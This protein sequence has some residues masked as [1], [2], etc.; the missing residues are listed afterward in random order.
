[1]KKEK[2]S[3]IINQIGDRHIE[4]AADFALK[5]DQRTREDLVSDKTHRKK[6]RRFRR[7]IA[8]ACLALLA[9]F[10]S[11]AFAAALEI[12]EYH[13]AAAFFDTNGLSADGL[14]RRDVKAVYRDITTNRFG[15]DK[16]AEVLR[17]AVPDWEKQKAEPTSEELAAL[18]TRNFWTNPLPSEDGSTESNG[19]DFV[20]PADTGALTVYGCETLEAVL[21]PAVDIFRAEYPDVDVNYVQLSEE[22]FDVRISTELSAGKG[23]DLL[24]CL[25]RDTPDPYR[26]MTVRLFEDLD[27]YFENDAGFGFDQYLGEVMNCGVLNGERQLVPVEIQIPLV[28]TSLEAVSE[29]MMPDAVRRYQEYLSEAGEEEPSGIIQTFEDFCSACIRYHE[30][31]PDGMLF[32]AGENGDDLRA[33]LSASGMQFI[34]YERGLVTVREEELHT[35]LDVCRAFRS[36]NGQ[37]VGADEKQ[38]DGTKKNAFLSPADSDPAAVLSELQDTR[39]KGE[40]PCLFPIYDVDGGITA[41]VLS[42][43]AI[44]R[45]SQNKL[46]AYRLLCILLSEEIQGGQCGTGAEDLHA[47]F[48]VLKSAVVRNT[49]SAYDTCFSGIAESAEDAR[50]FIDTCTSVTRASM[51]PNVIMRT[52]YLEMT[53]YI[54]GEKTWEEC[55]GRLLNALTHYA[56]G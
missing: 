26:T 55:Y 40:T 3:A 46:N 47:G 5:K 17:Q 48:P 52:L 51:I 54:R 50:L 29:T 43:A 12:R 20:M 34:D 30:E 18:W 14:N 37:T 21:S 10:G 13:T 7:S 35:I 49:M 24:F 27:P 39:R 38:T 16:T 23:P 19:S 45:S 2:V 36:A 28:K 41:E 25:S 8:A 9:V 6:A 53:P 11:A 15:Y 1:M 22:E 4:E 42:Y 44:L 33:L 32:P 56:N 31:N